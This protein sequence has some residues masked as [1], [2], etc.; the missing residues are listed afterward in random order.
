MNTM[1]RVGFLGAAMFVAGDV[2]AAG[3]QINE[4]AAPATGRASSVVATIDDPSSIFH[5]AAGLTQTEGTEFMAGVSF[6]RPRGKFQPDDPN[7]PYAEAITGFIP[8]PYA[9]LSRA[10][11]SKAF[12]GFGFYA[13]YGLGIKWTELDHE[14]EFIGSRVIDELSLRTFFLTPA[15][16]LKLSDMLSVAVSVSLVPSTVYLRRT[17]GATDDVTQSLFPAE[18][19]GRE[20]RIQLSGSAFG[21]GA[22]AGIQMTFIEHLKVG[23]NFRSAVD[24]SFSGN[25]DFDIPEGVPADV[26]KRFPDGEGT[27]EVTLPHAFALGVGWVDGPLTIE[28]GAQLTLWTSF[29]ELR[30]NF[31][32]G[33]PVPTQGAPRDWEA[34][35]LFRAG[36]QYKVTEE[37]ALRLGVGYDGTPVPD[38][39]IDPTLPDNNRLLWTLG[40]GY[41]F[42]P[43]RVDA[44]YMMLVLGGRRSDKS[45]NFGVPGEYTPGLVH[46]ISLAAGVEI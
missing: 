13:P 7:E 45:V 36:G 14:G 4:H 28:A 16:A 39:T 26:A 17:L 33:L 22:N 21:V 8:V 12:V 30:I 34:S 35:V 18:R 3:F 1:I 23:F 46:V 44:G 31:A 42:G 11:S 40:A 29:K 9:Y 43:V 37:L 27:A 38:E 41:D 32:S 19:Y 24:L 10:L 2:L 20:G 6:I 5:N 25:A 15:I